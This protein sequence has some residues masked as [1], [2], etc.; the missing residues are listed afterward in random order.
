MAETDT[1][2][3]PSVLPVFLGP[4]RWRVL[5]QSEALFDLATVRFWL[6]VVVTE[7]TKKLYV[8]KIVHAF[9]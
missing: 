4:T 8:P 2:H 5:K 3:S 9:Q 1:S 7:L 6:S